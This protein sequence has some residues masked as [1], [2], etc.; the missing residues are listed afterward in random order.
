MAEGGKD[1]ACGLAVVVKV[2]GVDED[3]VHVAD[4]FPMAD[5]VSEDVIHHGLECCGEL[6][7]LKNI[8]QGSYSPRLVVKAAFHSSPSL[9]QMLLKPQQRSSPVNH[10]AVCSRDR[11]SEMRGSG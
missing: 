2:F 3:V 1:F 4:E 6:H 5:E 9:I 10:W 7:R 11:T 8:T